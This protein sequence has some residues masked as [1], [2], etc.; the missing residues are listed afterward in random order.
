MCVQR[1]NLD[2]A[3]LEADWCHGAFHRADGTGGESI[4]GAKFAVSTPHASH[5]SQLQ[6]AWVS[7]SQCC[8]VAASCIV[9]TYAAHSC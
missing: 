3:L 9:T 8:S 7:V 1:G 5:T 2:Y 4:Y 6:P